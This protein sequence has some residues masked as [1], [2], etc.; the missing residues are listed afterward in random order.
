MTDEEL[1]A[2]LKAAEDADDKAEED[3]AEVVVVE[4]EAAP[5]DVPAE[6]PEYPVDA[7]EPSDEMQAEDEEEEKS[8]SRAR[9]LWA[10][11]EPLLGLKQ[12]KPD[13][14]T[15]FKVKGDHWVALWSNNFEDR[16]GE[17]FTQKAIDHYVARVD[18]GITPPPA[19]S[20]WHLDEKHYIG[21]ADWVAREGH[22]LV[23]AGRFTTAPQAV[24]DYYR[25]H[26]KETSLSHGFTFPAKSFDG[27]H[28]HEFNTFEISLLP[29][30]AEANSYTS[31][32][33][34]KA[35][36]FDER[37]RNYLK[38]IGYSEQEVAQMEADI[39][40]RGKS[41]EAA[42]VAFKDFTDVNP[43]ALEAL[44]INPAFKALLPELIGADA[45]NA[46]D[47]AALAKAYQAQNAVVTDLDKRLKKFEAF[48]AQT[49]KRASKAEET[50]LDEEDEEDAEVI[51]ALMEQQVDPKAQKA[52]P[53][54]Y[55]RKSS[56]TDFAT[57][58]NRTR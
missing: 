27:K 7:N 14:N 6:D 50:E 43:A 58:G 36:A 17:I 11:I 28:Y 39:H 52:F 45:E 29:R 55:N 5:E 9:R 16:D 51:K 25:K 47:T 57:P 48:M 4:D 22:F 2:F 26:A 19:L 44:D 23:A 13:L 21:Q 31:L 3:T 35:M 32:E 8:L 18:A 20:I 38:E 34:V 37:K 46:Q 53:G 33:G 24:K 15:S 12:P 10:R 49:P 30:G 41:H 54:F 42:G 1:I 40:A 56:I